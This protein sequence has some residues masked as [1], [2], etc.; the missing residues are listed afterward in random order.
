MIC[1][2]SAQSRQILT[3]HPPFFELTDVAA[4]YAM[5]TGHRPPRPNHRDISD[6]LWEMV[7]RCWHIVPSQR[8]SAGEAVIRLEAE[9]RCTSDS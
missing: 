8:M 1:T 3:G 5:F 4:T 2:R 6:R 9:L 7:E